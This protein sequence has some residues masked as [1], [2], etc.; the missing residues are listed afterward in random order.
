MEVDG[1]SYSGK[2]ISFSL[3]YYQVF[4]RHLEGNGESGRNINPVLFNVL[5]KLLLACSNKNI[6]K[7]T[8]EEY[9]HLIKLN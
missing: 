1:L 5:D 8:I 4:P 3:F 6:R 7:L 2:T 9:R